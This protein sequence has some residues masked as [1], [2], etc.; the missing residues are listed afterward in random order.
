M[1]NDNPFK[2]SQVFVI[3]SNGQGGFYCHNDIFKLVFWDENFINILNI[4][5][6]YIYK[7]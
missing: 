5:K 4:S 2:F 7:W 1:D 6:I 3:V